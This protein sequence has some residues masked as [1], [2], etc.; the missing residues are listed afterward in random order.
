MALSNDDLLHL[1]SITASPSA[2]TPFMKLKI[3]IEP[4]IC[5]THDNLLVVSELKLR[6]QRETGPEPGWTVRDSNRPEFNAHHSLVLFSFSV[7]YLMG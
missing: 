2:F 6:D 5:W 4:N 1:L 7:S 3:F